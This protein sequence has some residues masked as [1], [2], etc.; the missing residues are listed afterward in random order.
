MDC[1]HLKATI[2]RQ[3]SEWMALKQHSMVNGA[4][5]IQVTLPF[6]KPDG[7]TLCLYVSERN[8]GLVVHDGGQLGALL[9]GLRQGKPDKRDK[10]LLTRLLDQSGLAQEPGDG[11]VYIETDEAGL[12]Y[13]LMELGWVVALTPC[14]L[15]PPIPSE[16]GKG[17]HELRSA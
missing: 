12:R 1:E 3:M 17:A 13:W 4:P 15:D 16:G 2:D 8:G 14:L 11:I 9:Y 7:D 10:E 6:P 5:A